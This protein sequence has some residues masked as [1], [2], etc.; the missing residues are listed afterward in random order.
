MEVLKNILDSWVDLFG[1]IPTGIAGIAFLIWKFQPTIKKP[2]DKGT[3][4]PP[5]QTLEELKD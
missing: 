3:Y 1:I 5:G 4:N 2:I